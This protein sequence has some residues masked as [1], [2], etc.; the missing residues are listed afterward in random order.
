MSVFASQATATHSDLPILD[1]TR[2]YDPETRPQFLQEL[3][4]LARDIGFFYLTGHGLSHARI[5]EI[6]SI[7]QAF[8]A[9]DQTEKQRLSMDNSPH[10]RG[11]TQLYAENTRNIPD[12]RE[13]IDIGPELPALPFDAA[14]PLWH[15]LQGP[16]QWPTDWD[17]FQQVTTA[18][19]RDLR[20]I[21]TD[22]LHAF[23]LA[24]KVPENA[25]DA[26]VTGTPNE[27]LKLIHYPKTEL[28][29]QPQQGVGAHKDTNI[30]TLLLQDQVGGLQVQRD[31]KWI[32]VPYVEDAFVINIG[33]TLELATN[34][35][36]VANT[37]RV[38]SPTQQDRYSIAYFISPNVFAGDLP[39]LQL[40][41]ELQ[42][43][44]TGS[45]SDPLNPLLKSIGQNSIKSRLRSHL[46]VTAKFYPAQYQ[47][48]ISNPHRVV[49]GQYDA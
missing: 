19:L 31:G 1:L 16:N 25:L 33:E 11:Y 27:L 24:L 40:P 41:A 22:L 42:R 30:L 3:Q 37:H 21:A 23:M 2:F 38:V 32:D 44:A 34:G 26:F 6:E 5:E 36:L 46:S 35:Y 29:H 17:E 28:Q 49:G 7:S 14:T 15:R 48:I 13:Q 39:V 9:L 10:F 20:R 12:A 47:E 18:W 4:V 45:V 8:F 43:L